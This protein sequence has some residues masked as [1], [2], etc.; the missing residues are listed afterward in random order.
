MISR[1]DTGSVCRTHPQAGCRAIRRRSAGKSLAI[2]AVVAGTLCCASVSALELGFEGLLSTVANDNYSRAVKGEER[3][4]ISTSAAIK[5]YGQHESR[6]VQAAFV[7][8][9]EMDYT[10]VEDRKNDRDT[11]GRFN[12]AMAF[13]LTPEA[14]RWVVSD[15]IGTVLDCRELVS[16][17][18]T[19]NA[20]IRRNVF[21]TGPSFR[22]KYRRSGQVESS[23]YFMTQDQT[24]GFEIDDALS[25]SFSYLHDLRLDNRLGADLRVVTPVPGQDTDAYR[26]VSLGGWWQHHRGLFQSRL[27]TGITAYSASGKDDEI[28]NHFRLTLNRKV[29]DADMG[30]DIKH[31]MVDF[32]LYSAEQLQTTGRIRDSQSTGLMERTEYALTFGKQLNNQNRLAV[33]VGGEQV[34][35]RALSADADPDEEL[36]KNDGAVHFV[37]LNLSTNWNGR[38]SSGIRATWMKEKFDDQEDYTEAR[39]IGLHL[40]Y[41]L[42]QDFLLHGALNYSD[43]CGF[44]ENDGGADVC[45]TPFEYEEKE[46]VLALKWVPPSRV[47]KSAVIELKSLID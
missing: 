14:L 41:R 4:V 13:K 7:G 42:N 33:N 18:E 36:G 20:D 8:D 5:I 39:R 34:R 46:I 3:D 6:K 15:T 35:Q 40:E 45:Q 12:G 38:I 1:N 11:F 19:Y 44:R 17:G 37:G 31:D 25:F 27:G 10:A 24:N 26:R 28:A 9:F 23:L 29:G 32:A 21:M 30:L 43:S 47:S 22:K 2:A 16:Q